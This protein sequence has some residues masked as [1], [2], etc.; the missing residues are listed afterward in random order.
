[1]AQ[2]F[3]SDIHAT[4]GVKDSS[5]DLGTSGQ[6]LSSTGSLTNWVNPTV[7]TTVI[8]KD[9][10]TA[11]NGQ[12]AFTLANTV[13]SEDKTQVYIDGAY[14]SKGGYTVSGTTL[15][16]DTGLETSSAVEVITFSTATAN[17]AASA[18]KLDTFTGDG[19]DLTFVLSEAVVDE[20]VT[21]VYI[22]GV[23]QNKSTYSIAADLVTLTFGSGNAP[24]NSSAIEV[25]SFKTITSTDGT[26][27]ATTFLGDLNG[28][29]NT[30]TTATTQSAGNN[31][32]KI[33]TTA[34]TDAKVAEAITN[35]TTGIAPSQDVV[36]DALA[37]KATLADPTFTGTVGGITKAMVGL[38]NVDN[39][40]D[41]L[42][43]VSIAGQA[44]L[45][46]KA[47]I[48]GPTFTGDTGAANLTLSGYLRGPASFVIDPA[49]HGDETGTLVVAGNLQVDG[50]TT[51]INSTTVSIDDLNFSIATDAADSAA[52]NGAGIT[53]GGAGASLTYSHSGTKF[54]LNKPLDVTGAILIQQSGSTGFTTE[55][56][57]GTGSFINLKDN[58]GSVFIGGVNSEF[59]VQTPGSS[60]SNKLTI[61]SGGDATF[62]GKSDITTSVSGF[63]ST[64]T[65]N[66]DDSQGLLVRTSDNDGGEYILDLQS[67]S[68]ATGTNYASKF[69]VAKGGDVG[70]GITPTSKLTLLGTSTA[71]SNTPSDAIV[72]IK[73]T[74][75]AHLLMGVANVFP[76]GAWI[77][78]DNTTQP[79]VLM[80]T[81]GN[82]G[83]GT[84]SPN[85]LL[86]LQ[87]SETGLTHNLKLN[88]GSAT[89]DYA[90]IAFQL[91]NGAGSGLNT[92]GGS[93]T[94]RPSVVLRAINEASNSAAGAFVVGTFTGGAN[95]ST[96]TE[97]F[98][99]S[100]DG[101]A[102]FKSGNNSFIDLDRNASGNAARI[103]YKTS[104]T[105]EFEAGLIGGIAGYHI[106]DGSANPL[107]TISSGGDATFSGKISSVKELININ[108]ANG[109]RSL[110]L[111]SDS[112]G[113]VWIGT[114]TTAA[115][116][117]LVTG[118]S[119][120]GLPSVNGVKRL[121]T[122]SLGTTIYATFASNTFPFRVNTSPGDTNIFKIA[123]TGATAIRMN[124]TSTLAS[125]TLEKLSNS[126]AINDTIGYLNFFS[127]DASTTSTGGVGGIAVKA[128]QSFNSGYTPSYMSFYTHAI[129][130]NDGTN[131][132]NV[133]E[134]M[135]ISS[136][137]TVQIYGTASANSL[138][139][140]HDSGNNVTMGIPF[141][142]TSQDFVIRNSSAGVNL[143][144]AATSWVSASDENIKENIT[145]LDNV[146]DKIKNIRCVNYNLKD[147][148]IYKKRL[149][150]I[151]QDF[152]NDFEEVTSRDNDDILGLRYTETIPI[153]M[154]AI[155]EQQT[156]IEDLKSR[157]E[158]LEG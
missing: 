145:S 23:Y 99:I 95:N 103:R 111:E 44:A 142:N 109:L 51:T 80:G 152:Q 38:S 156:I 88:K 14:Q 89:G 98:R 135:R 146:L 117:N 151:A 121:S 118:N 147:E 157:I 19:S 153:L 139:I 104:G 129:S 140:D 8:Y 87:S 107:L 58:A 2:K 16:F 149:G 120:N 132:G 150:F 112:S 35:G 141:L 53:I 86:D 42:K 68:S 138:N 115:T 36:F 125:L 108:S 15:T 21:Q 100:S 43:P 92:F 3:L 57:G 49:A 29:I 110:G 116:I 65:N 25:I 33:S 69:K 101:T 5:G 31:S 131:I 137:G 70:I 12:T 22:N 133:T 20:K 46:L 40:T 158:T 123:D 71:A 83:I 148:E 32:T 106:S 24:P 30:A 85:Y 61:S 6:V 77:N 26:L 1:M 93:G 134:R 84:S 34:Y 67:S 114:G 76:Y 62:S 75:T 48:A 41:A 28:T 126:V 78:T 55:K 54:V 97:K 72:D 119:T 90:E 96:L 27:T 60:Y 144:Y 127:N 136:G 81:G 82:V 66:K 64:I 39:T 128:H 18:V 155:Q 50:T 91:W 59:V 7:G 9:A 113:N 102:T 74:S 122:N 130:A 124:P 94:S 105:D 4:A 13:D 79:L 154:K 73:G 52:A 56:T 143:D 37:L 11:T 10:F 63:A 17:N 45:D 47:N